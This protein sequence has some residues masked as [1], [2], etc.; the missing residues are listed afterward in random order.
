MGCGVTRSQCMKREQL[1][2]ERAV[3]LHFEIAYK[4]LAV[5]F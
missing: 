2:Y 4:E 1:I 5:H 3:F